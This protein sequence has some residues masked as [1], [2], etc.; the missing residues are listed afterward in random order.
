MRRDRSGGLVLALAIACGGVVLSACDSEDRRPVVDL[1]P[2]DCFDDD[3]L[4]EERGTS[5]RLTSCDRPHD[6]EV[7][8]LLPSSDTGESAQE[9]CNENELDLEHPVEFFAITGVQDEGVLSVACV[10]FRS[11]FQPLSESLA[12]T[13]AAELHGGAG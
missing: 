12:E 5:V 4:F 11:D 8:W 10:V 7:L 1:R 3:A 9:R 2:G 6:N 13:S